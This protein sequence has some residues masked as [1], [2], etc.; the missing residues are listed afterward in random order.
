[1]TPDKPRF[2]DIDVQTKEI[3]VDGERFSK[4][5]LKFLQNRLHKKC[6]AILKSI[7]NEKPESF[8]SRVDQFKELF[9]NEFLFTITKCLARSADQEQG[10]TIKQIAKELDID[11]KN[12][13]NKFPFIKTVL[14]M[15]NITVNSEF[16]ETDEVQT[17]K[18]TAPKTLIHFLKFA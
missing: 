1:M 11:L 13:R 4:S 17:R 18:K 6:L 12:V 2:K 9:P 7:D 3:E 14:K 5:D 16:I 10:T 15:C 8:T